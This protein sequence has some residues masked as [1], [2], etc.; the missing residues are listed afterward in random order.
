MTGVGELITL[1]LFVAATARSCV[2][3]K[4]DEIFD[5]FRRWWLAH[6]PAGSLRAYWLGCYWCISMWAALL[7]WAPLYSV[8][9]R[10]FPAPW[11][12]WW[13]VATQAFSLLSVLVIDAQKLLNH[14]QTLAA[15]LVAMETPAQA[16]TKA[17]EV[18]D[19]TAQDS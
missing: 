12:V 18:A 16:T 4:E 6:V 5:G 17:D 14:K 7:V 9:T 3:I 2:L 15:M 11:W 13:P 8:F 19:G 10:P 1:I